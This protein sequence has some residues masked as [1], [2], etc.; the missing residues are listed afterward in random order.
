MLYAI[1]DILKSH[2]I[3]FA[4]ITARLHFYNFKGD[5]AW[6]LET[7]VGTYWNI[8]GFV[9]GENE[10]IITARDFCG[11]GDHDP[12][13]C[14]VMMHLQGKLGAGFYRQAFYLVAGSIINTLLVSPGPVYPA[15]EAVLIS[16]ELF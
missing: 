13:L 8:S 12:V 6:I 11:S 15:M 10:D 3:I 2:N 9:L 14:P 4:E 1:I 5:A 7:V 16:I